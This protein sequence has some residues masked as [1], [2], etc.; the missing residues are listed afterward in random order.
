MTIIGIMRFVSCI[1]GECLLLAVQGATTAQAQQAGF[2]RGMGLNVKIWNVEMPEN[3]CWKL[4]V[5]RGAT[6][7]GDPISPRSADPVPTGVPMCQG[8]EI[9]GTP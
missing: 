9:L 3:D 4:S 5:E 2:G 8:V 1:Q 6:G 7:C